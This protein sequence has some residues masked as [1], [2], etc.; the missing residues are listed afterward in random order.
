[1]SGE[2]ENVTAALP[3]HAALDWFRLAAAFLVIAIH[4]SPL[5]SFSEEADFFLT[6]VLARV[7]V[8]F[9]FMVTGQFVLSGLFAGENAGVGGVRGEKTETGHGKIGGF[10][11]KGQA[12]DKVK[13]YLKKVGLLYI[14]AVLLYVPL[15]VYAGHYQG[16]GLGEVLKML[17]FDGAFYHLWYF[18]ACILGTIL[19]LLL[20]KYLPY[21]QLL[22]FTVFLYLLAL[23]G[24]SYYGLTAKLP[25]L[26]G[27]Y[28]AGFQVSSY[29]R[30]GLLF[31]PLFLMLGAGYGLQ[32]TDTG[33]ADGSS[34]SGQGKRLGGLT[35]F[36][37]LMTA[38]AFLLRHLE[39]QRHDSMY[40]SLPFVMVF[41]Y[42]LLES[43]NGRG[44]SEPKDR[45]GQALPASFQSA[46]AS[47]GR[48]LRVIT[49]WMYVVHPAVIVA[50][51]LGAKVLHINSLLVE[52]SLVH[53]AAVGI[54]SLISGWVI[55]KIKE[56]WSHGKTL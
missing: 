45:S 22:A 14:A 6:R 1:M 13:R 55:W 3:G 7:A 11:G 29:T 43:A 48:A 4:T 26:P 23:L 47:A 46:A 44:A 52:Q 19:I 32:K 27:I 25:L 10:S 39:W 53:Y 41:L 24:D 28:E 9:F 12:A 21:R 20:S 30:N 17:V 34:A 16:I 18:P 40:I 49:A 31:A 35:V 5:T 33:N 36:F 54:I 8:P 50:V 2:K 51:R 37:L 42:S 56:L 38:E 15:G